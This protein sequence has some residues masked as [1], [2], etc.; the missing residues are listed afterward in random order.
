MA[1]I[2]YH[3]RYVGESGTPTKF[4]KRHY[5]VIATTLKQMHTDW[6]NDWMH[7]L[8]VEAFVEAF[9]SDNPR[10]DADR[11]REASN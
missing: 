11:F 3:D 5:V 8:Y 2:T 4:S 6:G 7:G 10:F 1:T 9:G